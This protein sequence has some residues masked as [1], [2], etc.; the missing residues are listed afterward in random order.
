[1][2][3][4]CRSIAESATPLVSALGLTDV[5]LEEVPSQKA[6]MQFLAAG[7]TH[8]ELLESTSPDGPIAKFIEKR[9]EGL[10]HIALLVSDL[11]VAL[12]EARAAGLRLV[13]EFPRPG[14]RGAR[15]AFLHPKSTGGVLIE[16]VERPTPNRQAGSA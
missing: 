5:A 16:L 14:A 1:M 13:D 2:G 11:D 10:H 12:T 7:E 4:A 15:I 9:G 6:R 8:V 3:V